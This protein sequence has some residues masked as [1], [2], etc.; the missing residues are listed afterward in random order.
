MVLNYSVVSTS[1][2]PM[3][4]SLSGSCPLVFL[5]INTGVGCQGL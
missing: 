5:D 2:D 3:D 4:Y 1:C